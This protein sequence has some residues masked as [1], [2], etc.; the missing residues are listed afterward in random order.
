MYLTGALLI[1]FS[2]WLVN[3]WRWEAKWL[4]FEADA[5]KTAA[6]KAEQTRRTETA[7]QALADTTSQDLKHDYERVQKEFHL[8]MDRLRT[9][10]AE[11]D[12]MRAE[13]AGSAEQVPTAAK[14]AA[15]ACKACPNRSS[16]PNAAGIAEAMKIARDCDMTAFRYNRLLS[17][18]Q[19]LKE[20][21]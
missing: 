2:G 11:L 6:E 16:G 17:L 14:L 19:Q 21:Q 7:W 3:G 9:M 10:S 1:F 13:R 20:A 18:Y 8:A 12:R 5:F 15:G 4:A